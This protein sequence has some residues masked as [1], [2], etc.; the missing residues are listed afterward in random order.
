MDGDELLAMARGPMARGCCTSRP[1]CAAAF[2]PLK[3]KA[4]EPSKLG[5][6]TQC[7]P[8]GRCELE[9]V[10]TI[11]SNGLSNGRRSTGAFG[12][13]AEAEFHCC[14]IKVPPLPIPRPI[15]SQPTAFKILM[16]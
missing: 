7:M 12:A 1:V 2:E 16:R 5:D 6:I 3:K 8:A 11:L 13:V 10:R 4:I 9:I 14:M 15:A